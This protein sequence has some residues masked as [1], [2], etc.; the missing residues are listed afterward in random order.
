MEHKEKGSGIFPS[1]N[2][3]VGME[4][5]IRLQ[6]V[7][8]SPAQDIEKFCRVHGITTL[9][10]IETVWLIV[11]GPFLDA[12]RVCF[13]YRDH[14]DRPPDP[15]SGP[16]KVI[17]S[18]LFPDSPVAEMLKTGFC[19]ESVNPSDEQP[20]AHN[21]AVALIKEIVGPDRSYLLKEV[22]L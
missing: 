18:D 13:G 15:T 3:G 14:R 22:R 11:L 2:D 7:L 5:S 4:S 1:L 16:A 8:P 9:H 19:A 21:T 6:D 10:F 12:D 20:P 17:E